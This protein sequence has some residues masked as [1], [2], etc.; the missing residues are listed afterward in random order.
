MKAIRFENGAVV[1]V[2]AP[3]PEQQAGDALV[4]VLMAGICA[5]DIAIFHGY[6]GFTG[7][8]GHEFVGVVEKCPDWPEMEGKRVVADINFGCGT[9]ADEKHCTHRRV[10]G[11]RGHNGAFAAYCAVPAKNLYP[12]PASV[13]TRPA[14]FTE[15]LAAA[16]EITRQ[17]PLGS[18]S[19]VAVL[20]DG[21]LGILCALGLRQTTEGVV[22]LGR[23][24]EKLSIA[25]QQKVNTFLMDT[26]ADPAALAS[27]LGVFDI[28]VDATGNAEGINWCI[29]LT[30]P[31]GTVLVKTT[32][33]EKSN[34]DMAPVVVNELTIK[35][36]RCGSM[37][38]A[39]DVLQNHAVD[40]TPL[41]DA[42]YPFSRFPEAFARAMEKGSLKVLIDL[43]F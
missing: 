11:I 30:R 6:A 15:P 24:Q 22:L 4:R 2:D 35:G 34:I 9:C 3:M 36:S 7:I 18:R 13:E 16:L 26:H 41:I 14:A 1:T 17:T 32:T 39:L 10:L 25:S 43:S 33:F 5:T 29:P 38:L 42:V 27:Q 8:P 20:G 31:G 21:C 12:V 37:S 19:R 23:H 28:T 40:V